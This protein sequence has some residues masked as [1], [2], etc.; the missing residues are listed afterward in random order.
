M[1][2]TIQLRQLTLVPHP[3]A[4]IPAPSSPDFDAFVAILRAEAELIFDHAS[5]SSPKLWHGGLVET[6]SLP[7]EAV[8]AIPREGE[9]VEEVVHKKGFW[10][11]GSAKD[12]DGGIGWHM[13][14]TRQTAQRSATH[15]GFG[16]EAYWETLGER[17]IEQEVEYLPLL[18]Q[19]LPVGD[20]G[21]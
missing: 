4:S 1:T 3:L 12:K 15:F 6:F 7:H 13:R 14:R 18:A 17:H 2:H 19:V 8:V 21:G 10:G 20:N 9:A 11:G 5:W 16:F